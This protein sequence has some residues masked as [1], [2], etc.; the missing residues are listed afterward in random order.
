MSEWI[1]VS[2]TLTNAMPFW[3]DDPPFHWERV[4]DISGTG[5]ANVS[6]ITTSV[7]VGTHIDAPLHFI[8]EGQDITELELSRLCG[9]GVVIHLPE[10]RDVEARDLESAK[11]PPGH[12]VLI[13]TANEAL[14]D[15]PEFR[16]DFFGLSGEAAMWLVDRDVPLVGVDYLS[17]DRYDNNEKPAHYALLGNGVIIVEG[18]D[19]SRAAP[20]RY[21]VVALPLKIAGSDGS[22]ARVII[23][24]LAE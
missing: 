21:E 10:P 13:R 3:P 15:E 11:I 18:L 14:W 7:H 6:R 1:D 4:S 2:R 8:N 20:G 17:V 12:R 19:L 9:P 16:R 22:P 24:P 23:R 5:T